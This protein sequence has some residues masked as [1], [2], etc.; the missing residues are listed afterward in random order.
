MAMAMERSYKWKSIYF[1]VAIIGTVVV[2][3]SSKADG[4][5]SCST[6]VSDL[7]PCLSYISGS[8]AQPTNGCCNGI[9]TLNTTAK[10]TDD[11]QAV[12][13][14]IKSAV[15]SYSIY[16]DKASKLPGVCGVNLGFAWTPSLDCST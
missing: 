10:T 9:K 5:I 15:S 7:I 13:N 4:A 16:F 14:C 6:V 12:C 11:R 3:M 1:V 2:G 8:S